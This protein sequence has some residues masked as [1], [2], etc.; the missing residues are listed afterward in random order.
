MWKL[1]FNQILNI[2]RVLNYKK[3]KKKNIENMCMYSRIGTYHT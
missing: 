3:D 2:S 1:R